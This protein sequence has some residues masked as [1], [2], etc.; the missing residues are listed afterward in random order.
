MCAV[1]L[2]STL[3]NA[4]ALLSFNDSVQAVEKVAEHLKRNNINLALN[5]VRLLFFISKLLIVTDSMLSLLLLL[6]TLFYPG[7]QTIDSSVVCT[8]SRF[9]I[10]SLT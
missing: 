5:E 2:V 10:G 8:L 6:L 4:H 7:R 9:E 3:A 1:S